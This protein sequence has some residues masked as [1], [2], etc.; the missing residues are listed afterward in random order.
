MDKAFKTMLESINAQLN[1]LNRNG[2]AIYDADNPEYFISCI[3]YDSNSDEVIFETM[4][5]ERKLE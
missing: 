1:I 4:E 2:Y 3:K 5:D